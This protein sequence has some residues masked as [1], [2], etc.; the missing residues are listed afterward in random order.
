M[1]NGGSDGESSSSAFSLSLVSRDLRH[2]KRRLQSLEQTVA[3]LQEQT[4]SAQAF[5]ED[6][7]DNLEAQ[8]RGT[9]Q[10]LLLIRGRLESEAATQAARVAR[11]EDRV[12]VIRQLLLARPESQGISIARL[13]RRLQELE[14]QLR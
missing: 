10:D 7:L 9:D 12:T 1:D 3:A 2:T 8:R 14:V 11:L 6:H 4:Q 13:S 5:Q